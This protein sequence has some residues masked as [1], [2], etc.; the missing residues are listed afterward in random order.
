MTLTTIEDV[1]QTLASLA[2]GEA[3]PPADSPEFTRISSLIGS[4][5]STGSATQREELGSR[6]LGILIAACAAHVRTTQLLRH[7]EGR[8]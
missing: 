2:A 8:S 6:A 1:A 7:L 5:L 3:L 4:V